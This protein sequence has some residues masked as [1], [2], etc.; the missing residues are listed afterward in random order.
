MKKMLNR[1]EVYGDALTI[2]SLFIIVFIFFGLSLNIIAREYLLSIFLF[3]NIYFMIRVLFHLISENKSFIKLFSP[4]FLGL[5]SIAYIVYE[6]SNLNWLLD[7]TQMYIIALLIIGETIASATTVSIRNSIYNRP[8]SDKSKAYLPKVPL[9]L[10]SKINFLA[11]NTIL[12]ILTIPTAIF[13]FDE[14]LKSFW[15]IVFLFP[16]GIHLVALVPYFLFLDTSKVELNKKIFEEED[17]NF[18]LDSIGKKLANKASESCRKT[19]KKEYE[20][21]KQCLENGLD[22]NEIF[23]DRYTLLLP[24]TCCGDEKLVRLL[25]E[26]GADVNFRSKLGMT[27]IY[28]A[29]QHDAYDLTKLLIEN[30]ANI[31]V[32]STK[33]VKSPLIESTIQGNKLIVGT[34]IEAGADVNIKDL[35][36][37]TA[38]DYAKEKGFSDIARILDVKN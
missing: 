38:L 10:Q 36:G 32:P 1:F 17:K 7:N 19:T 33:D 29:T 9:S 8:S 15:Y 26:K 30:G 25:I 21:V 22:P 28:L 14:P 5:V 31:D 13:L 3:L 27:A 2:N 12:I 20:I 4:L 6:F 24:S 23:E 35:E 18:L 16:L 11:I 37:K 34:L